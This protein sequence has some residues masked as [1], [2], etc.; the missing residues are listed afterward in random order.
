MLSL[1]LGVRGQLGRE[2]AEYFDNR[3]LDYIGLDIEDFD[4]RN[5]D[6]VRGIFES[7]CPGLIINCS[8]YTDVDGAESNPEEVFA[9]NADAPGVIAEA[10]RKFGAK[11]VH[12][13][14]DYVFS[15]DRS[16]PY[17]E[18]DFPGPLNTYGK[19][20]LQGEKNIIEC[21]CDALIIRTS[22]LYGNGDNNFPAK[23]VKWAKEKPLLKISDDTIARSTSTKYL[24]IR[25]MEALDNEMSGLLH[26]AE[27]EPKTFYRWALQ[28][29]EELSIDTKIKPCSSE[30]LN[31]PAKRPAYSVLASNYQL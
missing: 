30:S 11:F 29:A 19:S 7:V 8:A 27:S 6:E 21:G 10:A 13:S 4:I 24:V 28:I 26:I 1:I 15:G 18:D 5:A 25:T 22:R 20:K 16:Y 23:I 17:K 3:G 9:V 31:L 2:F 14:T 12:F